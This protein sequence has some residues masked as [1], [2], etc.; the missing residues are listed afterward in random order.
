MSPLARLGNLPYFT[1]TVC[2]IGL[3][4]TGLVSDV[5]QRDLGI[6]PEEGRRNIQ[7]YFP[8]AIVAACNSSL[9]TET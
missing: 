5:L 7:V 2:Y 1:Y 4:S 6:C 8:Y 9:G 3:E